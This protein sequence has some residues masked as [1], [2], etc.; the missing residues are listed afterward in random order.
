MTVSRP[1]STSAADA[2]AVSESFGAR[3]ARQSRHRQGLPPG[4][5]DP[6]IRERLRVLCGLP[7]Q[8]Q[9]QSSAACRIRAICMRAR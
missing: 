2:R 6:M 5:A 8:S 4:I 7:P 3:L 1:P 9:W